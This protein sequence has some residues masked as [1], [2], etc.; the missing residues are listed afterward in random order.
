MKLTIDG[1]QI[2][3]RF[4]YPDLLPGF[5]RRD[6]THCCIR[7]GEK[8]FRGESSCSSSDNFSYS[9]GRRIAL[10]R[11]V[12]KAMNREQRE[13]FWRVFWE[14]RNKITRKKWIA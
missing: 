7:I 2:E 1:Q 6:E 4:K 8:E 14:H 11:A 9:T 12:Q 13:V 5:L 3:I 10:T